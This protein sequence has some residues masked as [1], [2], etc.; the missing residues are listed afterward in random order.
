MFNMQEWS[1]RGVNMACHFQIEV[2]LLIFYSRADES[3]YFDHF[4]GNG[5]LIVFAAAP[6]PANFFVIQLTALTNRK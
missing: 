1:V 2:M 3:S 6:L 4:L 5:C